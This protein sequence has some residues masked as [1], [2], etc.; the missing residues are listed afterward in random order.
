MAGIGYVSVGNQPTTFNDYKIPVDESCCGM[1]FDYGMRPNPFNGFSLAERYFGNR[2][3]IEINN[4]QDAEKNG[5]VE[6]FFNGIPH[7][8]IAQFYNYIGK[9]APLYVMIADCSDNFE[10]IQEFQYTLNGKLFQIGVWTERHIWKVER[11]NVLTNENDYGFTSLVSELQEQANQL[12]GRVGMINEAVMP[13]SIVLCAN[14]A[15]L[16]GTDGVSQNV[17]YRLLPNG[18]DLNCSKVSVILGQNG[19]DEVHQ[20]QSKNIDNCPV[21]FLGLAIACLY[22]ASAENSIGN[23]GVF[24]LN[25]NGDIN[26]VEL[27]FDRDYSPISKVIKTRANI[28]AQNGYV[29]PVTYQSKE[30]EVFFSNDQTLSNGDYRYISLNRVINKCRR[31]ARGVL[32]PYLNG[33]MMLTSDGRLSPTMIASIGN[34]IVEKLDSEMI[35]DGNAQ[36]LGREVTIDT[37]QNIIN[38][39]GLSLELS[40]IP[41]NV[42]EFINV[43]ENNGDNENNQQQ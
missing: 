26:D 13:I 9:D 18:T 30:S 35:A 15:K 8:H 5:I 1:L 2:Q 24:D 4:I 33:Q 32:L 42:S 38:N 14:T 16:N 37:D 17:K 23:V 7:Y 31:I 21:G 22:L 36:I 40:I 29:L 27:G 10:A 39:D 11:F 3:I 34:A 43:A 28:I 6:D 41:A 19:T 20:M 12:G 25:K